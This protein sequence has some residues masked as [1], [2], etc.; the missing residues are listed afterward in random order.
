MDTATLT[1]LAPVLI[2]LAGAIPAAA[3]AYYGYRGNAELIAMR[4]ELQQARLDRDRAEQ[5]ID[6]LRAKLDA[7]EGA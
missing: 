1:A 5:K 6:R 2:A 4:A 7:G 3:A